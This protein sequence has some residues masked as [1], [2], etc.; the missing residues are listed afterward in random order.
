MDDPLILLDMD[1][2]TFNFFAAVCKT[3]GVDPVEGEKKLEPLDWWFK[4][5][6]GDIGEKKFW[7]VVNARGLSFW[8]EMEPYP[9]ARRLYEGLTQLAPVMFLSWPGPHPHASA[10][11]VELLHRYFP[12]AMA[13]ENFFLGRHKWRL[14]QKGHLLVEDHEANVNAFRKK[15]DAILFPRRWNTRHPGEQDAADE[16]LRLAAAWHFNLTRAS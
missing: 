2:V 1:G 8:T 13:E 14:A 5:V 7:E 6:I 10:G 3:F 16:T 4:S 9:F 11:K 12:E 15:G